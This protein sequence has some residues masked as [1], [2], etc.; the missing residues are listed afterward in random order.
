MRASPTL[1]FT[2]IALAM[3]LFAT[4]FWVALYIAPV[5]VGVTIAA[6]VALCL[7]VDLLR[8][9]RARRDDCGYTTT[10]FGLAESGPSLTTRTVHTPAV[11]VS[12]I[13]GGKRPF[14]RRK[15]GARE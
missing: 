5:V 2:A 3:I 12:V 11:A 14:W 7:L 4:G 15:I 8:R 6:L 10:P 13:E 1:K 9:V